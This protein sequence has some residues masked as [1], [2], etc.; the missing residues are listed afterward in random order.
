MGV[1]GLLTYVQE[2]ASAALEW[3]K[4]HGRHVIIDG[5]NLAFTIFHDGTGLNAAFGGDYDKYARYIEDF[6][7]RLQECEVTCHVVMDGGQP[8][9]NKKLRTVRQR[10]KDQISSAL[11]LN[12]KNQLTNK[13]FP[14]IGRQVLENRKKIMGYSVKT[15]DFDS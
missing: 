12:P 1:R 9:N 6:F 4:L 11:R 8:L 7:K 14:P 13:L 10:V 2:H 15:V 5:N 3:H